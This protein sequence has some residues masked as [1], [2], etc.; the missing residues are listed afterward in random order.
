[1]TDKLPLIESL[2]KLFI[3]TP[4]NSIVPELGLFKALIRLNIVDFPAPLGPTNPTVWLAFIFKFSPFNTSFHFVI[5]GKSPQSFLKKFPSSN[6]VVLLNSSLWNQL[7]FVEQAQG[8][9]EI[10]QIEGDEKIMNDS[11]LY[12]GTD[13][14]VHSTAN[15]NM[16]TLLEKTCQDTIFQVMN[17]NSILEKWYHDMNELNRNTNILT[18]EESFIQDGHLNI[19]VHSISYSDF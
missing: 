3:S 18:T 17:K 4:S 12:P 14:T 2:S 9:L 8:D 11:S 10:Q 7:S 16:L 6:K 15:P 13:S 5:E 19:N 1:M